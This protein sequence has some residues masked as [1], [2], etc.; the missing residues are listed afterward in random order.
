MDL[1]LGKDQSKEGNSREDVKLH[2]FMRWSTRP[3]RVTIP[4]LDAHHVP[5]KP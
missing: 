4:K 2:K 5:S 1:R 3:S